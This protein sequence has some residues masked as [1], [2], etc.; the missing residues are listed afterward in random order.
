MP[1]GTADADYAPGAAR[2]PGR[3]GD[4]QAHRWK[5]RG[6]CGPTLIGNREPGA[7]ERGPPPA[8][9]LGP[10]AATLIARLAKTQF[11]Q[12][13]ADPPSAQTSWSFARDHD[14]FRAPDTALPEHKQSS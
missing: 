14:A 7:K 13:L 10:I 5:G 6:D 11:T 4:V 8:F 3:F 1:L 12:V 9:L 2:Q